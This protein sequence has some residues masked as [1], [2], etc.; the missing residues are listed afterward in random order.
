MEEK[1]TETES[2]GTPPPRVWLKTEEPDGVGR[3]YIT[4][5]NGEVLGTVYAQSHDAPWG[6][7]RYYRAQL[8]F[9]TTRGG[10][11]CKDFRKAID[12]INWVTDTI[13]TAAKHL[14]FYPDDYK[15]S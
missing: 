8:Y 7:E 13:R 11:N 5:K 3:T 15:D 14:T 6:R 2:V 12:A 4:N 9:F 10:T 1:H